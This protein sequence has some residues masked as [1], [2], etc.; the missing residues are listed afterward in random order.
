MEKENYKEKRRK[1]NSRFR[2][3]ILVKKKSEFCFVHEVTRNE[4]S[5]W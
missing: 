2:E 5:Y 3:M 4:A 1:R